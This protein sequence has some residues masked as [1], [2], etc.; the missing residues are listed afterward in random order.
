MH[1]RLGLVSILEFFA[2]N[3]SLEVAELCVPFITQDTN[4]AP[5]QTDKLV[6]WSKVPVA[7]LSGGVLHHLH[8]RQTGKAIG[9]P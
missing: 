6:V 2:Q 8:E 5:P 4:E 1:Q 7:C 9:Q 3:T